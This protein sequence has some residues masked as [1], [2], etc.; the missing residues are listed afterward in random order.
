MD[1]FLLRISMD[2]LHDEVSLIS[3]KIMIG[4][5]FILRHWSRVGTRKVPAR[6]WVRPA[7]SYV[8]IF[9]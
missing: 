7:R 3:A 5:L 9:F 2:P 4:A 6:H 1:S 8:S